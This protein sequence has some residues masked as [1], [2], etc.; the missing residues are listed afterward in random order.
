MQSLCP[1]VALPTTSKAGTI[2]KS[3]AL[4]PVRLKRALIA[5]LLLFAY[6][7]S[8]AHNAIPHCHHAL[9]ISDGNHLHAV[10]HNHHGT[11]YHKGEPVDHTHISHKDHLDDGLF[12]LLICLFSETEHPDQDESDRYFPSANKNHKKDDP[13]KPKLTLVVLAGLFMDFNDNSAPA[14]ACPEIRFSYIA[15]LVANAPHRGPPAISS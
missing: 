1:F 14:A 12:D 10:E 7:L 11:D 13:A 2:A 6:A 4:C 15:P 8:F 3:L 9:R 5:S